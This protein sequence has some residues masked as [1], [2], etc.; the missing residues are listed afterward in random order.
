MGPRSQ[1]RHLQEALSKF[2]QM[3]VA[4]RATEETLVRQRL[5]LVWMDYEIVTKSGL[6][7]EYKPNTSA[8]PVTQSARPQGFPSSH[9][10]HSS[11]PPSPRIQHELTEFRGMCAATRVTEDKLIK[12]KLVLLRMEYEILKMS[13]ETSQDDIGEP[14]THTNNFSSFHKSPSSYGSSPSQPSSPVSS[15]PKSPSP[16]HS[17]L[18]G[19]RIGEQVE[20]L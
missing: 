8:Q 9:N 16:F 7:I 1:H 10:F 14:V 17:G 15:K 12:Q 2:R 13:L 19:Y 3:C 11:R 20:V 5:I 4:T 6:Q 18:P